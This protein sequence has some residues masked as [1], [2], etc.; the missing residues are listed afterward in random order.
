MT[1][2]FDAKRF[3]SSRPEMGCIK[4]ALKNFSKNTYFGEHVQTATSVG[5]KI[6]NLLETNFSTA[7]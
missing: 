5:C 4:D 3:R 1:V 2:K 7:T 6:E